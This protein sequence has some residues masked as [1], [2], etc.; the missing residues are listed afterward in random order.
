[1]MTLSELDNALQ[2]HSIHAKKSLIRI[3]DS[4]DLKTFD[5]STRELKKEIDVP[6]EDLRDI[7]KIAA[8]RGA[9]GEILKIV[10]TIIAQDEI[11]RSDY[12]N[13]KQDVEIAHDK[14]HPKMVKL[15]EEI[16]RFLK[17]T[18]ALHGEDTHKYSGIPI[19]REHLLNEIGEY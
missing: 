1:M 6:I 10:Q 12:A 9:I 14:L 5:Y 11:G 7:K 8:L 4:I 2:Q 13:L 16:D 15:I 19:L 3:H 17:K 18:D